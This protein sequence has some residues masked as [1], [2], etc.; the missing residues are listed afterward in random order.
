MLCN[1]YETCVVNVA[2]PRALW[3]V[4]K[5]HL[6]WI[7]PIKYA[8]YSPNYFVN[9]CDAICET[10]GTPH[11]FMLRFCWHMGGGWGA[12]C[13][14]FL[15]ILVAENNFFC[16]VQHSLSSEDVIWSYIHFI[17]DCISKIINQYIL[18]AD[19]NK[20]LLL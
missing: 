1:C 3:R 15:Y 8:V 17:N 13:G 11:M 10:A 6:L 19:Q 5:D 14:R 2:P 7:L 9:V 12:A 16:Y 20:Y 18:V 4:C